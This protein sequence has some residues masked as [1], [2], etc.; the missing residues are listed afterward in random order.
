MVWGSW[1]TQDLRYLFDDSLRPETLVQICY[2]YKTNSG[3]SDDSIG[4][5]KSLFIESR[6]RQRV[7]Q[8]LSELMVWWVTVFWG[9]HSR[10]SLLLPVFMTTRRTYRN[11]VG[12]C[13]YFLFSFYSV[14]KSLPEDGR[15]SSQTLILSKG[16]FT[17]ERKHVLFSRS[18]PFALPDPHLRKPPFFV[19]VYMMS[20]F[21][22]KCQSGPYYYLYR[23]Y[24]VSKYERKYVDVSL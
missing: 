23:G 17:K 20:V 8:T 21:V 19:S 4:S 24:L 5:V 14:P 10:N 11:P 16:L 9:T 13:P 7:L 22:P 18:P 3:S 6:T 15:Q 1:F 12:R 2:L